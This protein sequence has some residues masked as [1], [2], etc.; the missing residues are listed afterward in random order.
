MKLPFPSKVKRYNDQFHLFIYLLIYLFNYRLEGPGIET[1][2]GGFSV[3]FQT[4]SGGPL[5][6]LQNGY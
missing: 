3:T 2:W 6:L 5:G 4:V 1:R